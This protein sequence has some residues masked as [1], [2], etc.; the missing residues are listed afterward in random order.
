MD[1]L[2]PLAPRHA[3]RVRRVAFVAS[4][5]APAPRRVRRGRAAVCC[6]AVLFLAGQSAFNLA[7]RSNTL[8]V[9]DPVYYEKLE[10]LQAR[11][12][13]WSPR[14]P[15]GPV[16][17][18]ALGSSRT[19]MGFD[20][21]RFAAGCGVPTEAFNFGVSS[22][23]PMTQWLYFRRLIDAGVSLDY[24]LIELHPGYLTPHQPCFEGRWLH[25]YRLRLGEPEL[26]RSC[27]YAV[28]TPAHHGARGWAAS[29]YEFRYG[30][31]NRHAPVLLP[32]PYGLTVGARNDASGFAAG[33]EPSPGFAA[34]ALAA[35]KSQYAPVFD[36][37]AQGGPG[38][39]AVARLLAECRERGVSAALVVT[40]EDSHFHEWYGP[41]SAASIRD[42]ARKLAADAGVPLFDAREWLDD[43]DFSD[44][45]H[46]APAGS[47]RYTDRLA[48]AARG[49]V[50]A[51]R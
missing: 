38:P 15:G 48:E 36:G 3:P 16:R 9:A 50:G 35:S 14:V 32:C 40:P 17:L 33:L 1:V 25:P 24:V 13:Y 26:L 47:R 51:A 12:A 34:K 19:H 27:G 46:M 28:A 18:V 11:P 45:H 43:G 31:L 41:G 44:G 29:V 20:A 5:S 23:G 21:A 6:A 49:W 7:L 10:L 8:S 22:G 42:N 30:L 2:S 4:P 39:V 37:F